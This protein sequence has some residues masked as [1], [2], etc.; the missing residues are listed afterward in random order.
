MFCV[1]SSG[2]DFQVFFACVFQLYIGPNRPVHQV[3]KWNA[4]FFEDLSS[5]VSA[6][7]V[8]DQLICQL[9]HRQVVRLHPYNEILC[10]LMRLWLKT[11]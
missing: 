9:F 10:I 2:F 6:A 11:E 3:D 7:V 8:T 5:L 4:W 1:P